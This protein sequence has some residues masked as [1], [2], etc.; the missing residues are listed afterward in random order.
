MMLQLTSGERPGLKNAEKHLSK[1]HHKALKDRCKSTDCLG[2][3]KL[4]TVHAT[5]LFDP[6]SKVQRETNAKKLMGLAEA[7]S[8]RSITDAPSSVAVLRYKSGSSCPVTSMA[9]DD[10]GYCGPGGAHPGN[11][12][13]PQCVGHDYCVCAYSHAEC[14]LNVPE[15]CLGDPGLGIQCASL[16]EAIGSVFGEIYEWIRDWLFGENPDPFDDDL[17]CTLGPLCQESPG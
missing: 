10:F 16:L 8:V 12:Q 5:G 1:E 6:M 13:T 11:L 2:Q 4:F 15:G 17:P 14:L 9:R 7:T 3:G